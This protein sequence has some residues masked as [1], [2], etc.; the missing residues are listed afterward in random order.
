MSHLGTRFRVIPSRNRYADMSPQVLEANVICIGRK[1]EG[2]AHV[3]MSCPI[4]IHEVTGKE[5]MCWWS[6]WSP[7]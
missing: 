4:Y 7:T 1:S 3:S 5:L 6:T 2:G